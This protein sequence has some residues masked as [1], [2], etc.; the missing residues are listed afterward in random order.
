MRKPSLKPNALVGVSLQSNVSV[1]GALQADLWGT[2]SVNEH[3]TMSK[4]KNEPCKNLGILADCIVQQW[5]WNILLSFS[6]CSH[7]LY[8]QLRGL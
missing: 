3:R 7:Q 1:W 4:P 6:Y 2:V 8:F 5:H